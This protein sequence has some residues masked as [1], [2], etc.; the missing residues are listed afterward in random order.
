ML[1]T[2]VI[3]E[4]SWHDDCW[5][6]AGCLQMSALCA[7]AGVVTLALPVPV[8][9][10]NFAL[11]YSHTKVATHAHTHTRTHTHARTHART[12]GRTHTHTHTHTHMHICTHKNTHTHTHQGR[13]Q[14][15]SKGGFL[16]FFKD[17]RSSRI[18]KFL[19]ETNF[20]SFIKSNNVHSNLNNFFSF[21]FL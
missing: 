6:A 7:L 8:I 20:S 3:S 1:D 18:D 2:C 13:I 21:S 11:F 14:E 5:I 16:N 9:V 10:A 19:R 15:W 4:S 17:L 12:H